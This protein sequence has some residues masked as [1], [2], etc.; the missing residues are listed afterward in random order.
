MEGDPLGACNFEVELGGESVGLSE[1][2]GL[3]YEVDEGRV[4]PVILRRGAGVD[5]TLWA[6]ARDP[7]PRTVTITLLDA[8][9]RPV[10]RYVLESA[11]PIRWSGP[12]LDAM[13]AGIATEE[14]VVVALGM[15]LETLG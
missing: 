14:L 12:T 13:S 5:L 1:V 3:A 8:Q 11:R 7:A 6:W 15:D 10:C 4:G 2:H 9:R